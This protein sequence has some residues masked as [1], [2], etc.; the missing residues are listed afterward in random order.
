MTTPRNLLS[1][2]LNYWLGLKMKTL[3]LPLLLATLAGSGCANQYV[4]KLSNGTE[5]IA[6]S[7]PH[8]KGANYYYKDARGQEVAIPQSRVTQIAPASMVEEEKKFEQP[9]YQ[10]PKRHWWQFWR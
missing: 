10:K 4:I 8:L 1:E 3:I 5:L 6:P 2:T 9:K 7:K